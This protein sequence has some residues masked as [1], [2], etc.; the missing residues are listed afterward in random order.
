[1]ALRD[2]RPDGEGVTCTVCHQISTARSG[3]PR[4]VHGRVSD[5]ADSEIYGPHEKPF[6]MPMQ[7]HT[8]LTPV[9]SKHVLES[10]LCGLCHTVITPTLAADGRVTGELI[11][12]APYLEWLASDFPKAGVTC[13]KCHVPPLRNASGT[14][15]AQYI[16]HMPPGRWFPPTQPRQPFGLH[17]FAGANTAMLDAAGRCR[18]GERAGLAAHGSTAL[19]SLHAAVSLSASAVVESG[20]LVVTVDVRNLTGHKLPTGFPSRRIWIHF[21]AFSERAQ[22]CS[23]PAPGIRAPDCSPGRWIANRTAL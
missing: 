20:R 7:H 19:E 10:S 22:R 3:H 6:A 8:G 11:E 16:A 1:M 21:Q 12:Q 15:A 13:Q 17:F 5:Q 4:I 18:T 9:E 14:M 23:N 2:L